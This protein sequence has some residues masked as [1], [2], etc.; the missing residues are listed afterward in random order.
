MI[1]F[2]CNRVFG[3]FGVVGGLHETRQTRYINVFKCRGFTE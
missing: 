1:N 3:V 2:V